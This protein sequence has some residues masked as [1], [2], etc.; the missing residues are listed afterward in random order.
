MKRLLGV[1]LT[2]IT[3][4]CLGASPHPDKL[5]V[6][7]DAATKPDH[8]PLIIA[9]HLGFFKEQNLDVEF[10]TPATPLHVGKAL[11]EKNVDLG[12]IDQPFL[13]GQIDHDSPLIRIGTLI[14]KPLDS[15]VVINNSQIHTI[16][17]L[18]GKR[19]A[20]QSNTIDNAML[21]AM[22]HYH[23][24]TDADVNFVDVKSSHT[25]A[26]LSHK[27]DASSSIKRNVDIPQ[28]EA[29]HHQH[30]TFLPEENGVPTYSVMIFA[31][32]TDNARD[33][34]FPRFLA[35]IKKAVAWL[36]A[37]PNDGWNIFI[38][39]YPQ[40]NNKVNHEAW[41]ATM[42]YF[43][44]EPAEFDERDWRKFADFMY[45]NKMIQKQQPTSRYA[46]VIN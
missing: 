6:M 31:S 21:K 1:I 38:K 45:E 9:Q 15:L 16:K 17:D 25:Q 12:I 37:H 10:I 28:L 14:D 26:L 44:E 18:K 33:P 42:P 19:I 40:A 2:I 22:L 41:F 4:T 7:L 34:R 29:A 5:T 30:A 46:I 11:T 32:H 3:T 23:G 43:A 20:S 39:N 36:D 35:A 24:L 8:A 13:M 27:I